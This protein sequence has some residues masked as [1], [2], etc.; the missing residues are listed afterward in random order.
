MNPFENEP[1]LQGLARTL[2][3]IRDREALPR[4]AETGA[5]ASMELA[6][7]AYALGGAAPAILD[8]LARSA[9]FA[10]VA[11]ENTVRATV[12]QLR[13][14]VWL[15]EPGREPK[16]FPKAAL[17]WGPGDWL[18]TLGAVTLSSGQASRIGGRA[19]QVCTPPPR[20]VD[21]VY[22]PYCLMMLEFVNDLA[23]R[24]YLPSATHLRDRIKAVHAKL[25]ASSPSDSV[26]LRIVPTVKVA[27][28]IMAD[29]PPALIAAIHAAAKAYG[30]LWADDQHI[31]LSAFHP[32]LAALV[33]V[34]AKREWVS[35]ADFEDAPRELGAP[36]IF[37]AHRPAL[38][39]IQIRRIG[40]DED[41]WDEW[42]VC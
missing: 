24:V 39:R 19:L 32:E 13:G 26:R 25:D 15:V 3:A 1:A 18:E 21:P 12:P 4:D 17:T 33:R 38:S 37:D 11:L 23:G 30:E 5:K 8:A 28:A 35:A 9:G 2:H 34:V 42:T 27:E 10:R 40:D 29:D 22:E 36:L 20:Q 7:R 31:A 16:P 14:K 41:E 6:Q